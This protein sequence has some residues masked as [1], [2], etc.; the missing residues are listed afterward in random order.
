MVR[1]WGSKCD[2]DQGMFPAINV[3]SSMKKRYLLVCGL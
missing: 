2:K 1:I 3:N